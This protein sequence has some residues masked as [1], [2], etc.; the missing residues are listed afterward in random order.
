MLGIIISDDLKWDFNTQNLVKK[1][2]C[3]AL[4][5]KLANFETPHDDLKLFVY[6]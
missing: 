1:A 5:R 3:M 2:N 4:L 6:F